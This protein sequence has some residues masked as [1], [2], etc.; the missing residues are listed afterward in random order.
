MFL[1]FS[2]LLHQNLPD[3]VHL[4]ASYFLQG[5]S[6][7]HGLSNVDIEFEVALHSLIYHNNY[8][9]RNFYRVRLQI[10]TQEIE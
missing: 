4:K 9:V 2:P 1:Q 3:R 6:S 7:G 5:G 8:N 10:W